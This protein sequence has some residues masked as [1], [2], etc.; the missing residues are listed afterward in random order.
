MI[1]DVLV[2]V[3]DFFCGLRICICT[4]LVVCSKSS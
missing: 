1:E 4:H 2:Y 3:L